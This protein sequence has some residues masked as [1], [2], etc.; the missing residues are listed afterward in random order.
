MRFKLD[1]FSPSG[2]S[3]DIQVKQVRSSGA[4]HTGAKYL[5]DLED[6]VINS[7]PSDN[8]A[9]SYDSASGKWIPQTISGSGSGIVETIVA[10]TNITV[11]ATDPANPIVSAT[12]GG[13]IS[14]GDKGD[15]TVSSSGTVWTID[16]QAV[17][18]SKLEHIQ[19]Q[20]FLGRHGAGTSDVQEVSPAQARTILN[21]E[22]GADVTD[23]TNV[24]AAGAFMK[25]SDDS[26]DI[27]EGVTKL[28]LTSA[29]RTKLTNTSGTNTGDQTITLTGDVTGSGTGSFATT[30]ANNAVSLAK[31]ADVATGTVFYR[32]T[33]STGDPEVQ[34]LATLKTDLGLTGTNSGDQTS[35]VGITGTTAEFNTALT[36]NDFATVAGSE[37]LT[38][39]TLTTPI[40]NGTPTGTG[41]ATA[42]TASTLALRDADGN[43][44]INNVLEGYTTTATAAG[45]TTLTVA[46][47]QGQ[48]FTGTTTQTVRMPVTST[49]SLGY[50]FYIVNNS[51]GLVTVQSSGANTIVILAA[52]TSALFTCIL[53]SGTTA[54]SWSFQYVGLTSASGK[55]LT[56]NNSIALTGTDGTTMTFPSSTTT[57]AGLGTTQTF[58]GANTFNNANVLA[59]AATMAVFNTTATNLSIG[60]AATTL[61]LGGTPTTAVTHNYSANATA[62]G[63]TK[64]VNLATGGAAGSTTNVNIGSTSGGTTTVN[65]PNISLGSTT[66]VTTTGTI[67][68][69][70]ASDTTLSRSSAG[71]LA[72]EGVAVPTI[73]SISTLTNKTLDTANNTITGISNNNFSTAAGEVGAA[74]FTWTPTLTNLSG[75]TL[76]LAKY[77]K[78]GKRIRFRFRYTLAGAG[79]SGNIRISLP[80]PAAADEHPAS[81]QTTIGTANYLDQGTANMLGFVNLDATTGSCVLSAPLT[82]ATYGAHSG[83]SSTIPMT[84]ASGDQI[85]VRGEYEST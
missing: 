28:F 27:T 71:V 1:P 40:L 53:T 77:S 24:A 72:V 43:F 59:G 84:W 66:G 4:V 60:G 80:V 2:I 31:M 8:Q 50:D 16:N 39:K 65:T 47:T 45:T 32:K 78:I 79:V 81:G 63:V 26:D 17:T 9:L 3:L 42:A 22:D 85:D 23:A 19:S 49:L 44:A 46:S 37:T 57:V 56:V 62:T 6:V 83:L 74:W 64:T 11:D 5:N 14:D 7:T 30:I 33:A 52:G 21:V 34:T 20:H 36:D 54:A 38:N 82:N 51:T 35:I 55:K 69:G 73:S 12:G 61:N 48:F 41:V 25:A 70:A 67:E 76:N 29:E 75:G 15:I 68:L 10:G 13:S 58:T 18:R